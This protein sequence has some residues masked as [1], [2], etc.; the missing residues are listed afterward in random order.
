VRNPGVHLSP[1]IVGTEAHRVSAYP[2]RSLATAGT[3]ALPLAS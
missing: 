3:G 1:F 2:A